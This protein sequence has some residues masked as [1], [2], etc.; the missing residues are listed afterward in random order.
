MFVPPNNTQ[1]E[2]QW[3]QVNRFRSY[4]ARFALCLLPC[5][6]G[7]PFRFLF[8]LRCLLRLGDQLRDV[9]H[10]PP[11]FNVLFAVKVY[12]RAFLG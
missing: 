1:M 11:C 6:W 2:H 7:S 8:D 10:F 12:A 9:T 5:S 4:I 3:R